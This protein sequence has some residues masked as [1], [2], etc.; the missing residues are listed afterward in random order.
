MF[1]FEALTFCLREAEN[2]I[3]KNI[4]NFSHLKHTHKKYEISATIAKH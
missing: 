2:T 3:E 1:R 4:H